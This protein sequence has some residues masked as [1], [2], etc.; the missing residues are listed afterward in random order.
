MSFPADNQRKLRRRYP[1]GRLPLPEA[2]LSP[3]SL[4]VLPK[5]LGI[6]G[7]I[8]CSEGLKRAASLTTKG[9][10]SPDAAAL[11]FRHFRSRGV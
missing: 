5:S 4:E 6:F 8:L 1:F 9:H 11:F 2:R 7:I 3:P 10:R